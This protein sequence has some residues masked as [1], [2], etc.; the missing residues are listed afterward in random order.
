MKYSVQ[1][2]PGKIICTRLLCREVLKCKE[3]GVKVRVVVDY[4][5]IGNSGCQVNLHVLSRAIYIGIENSLNSRKL[6]SVILLNLFL[7]F[8]LIILIFLIPFFS[9][10]K[11]L[12]YE[13]FLVL[14]FF[15]YT[16]I[17]HPL[18]Q[19]LNKTEL[20]TIN[21]KENFVRWEICARAEPVCGARSKTSS[22]TTS[23]P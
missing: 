10:E 13:R 23:L 15:R 9:C 8:S 11:K 18:L 22:C 5:N 14:K 7:S 6:L 19:L 12:I 16:L 2:W 21:R 20:N 1:Q 3:R 4:S 17:S